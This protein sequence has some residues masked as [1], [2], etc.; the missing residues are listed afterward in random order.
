[1][2]ISLSTAPASL[3]EDDDAD[4]CLDTAGPALLVDRLAAVDSGFGAAGLAKSTSS[5]AD[6]TK[7]MSCQA[8]NQ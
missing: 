2:N 4:D 6:Y 7:T 8:A 1:M 3:P 5:A